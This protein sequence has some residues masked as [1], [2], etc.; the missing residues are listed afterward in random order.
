MIA[1]QFQLFLSYKLVTLI[2]SPLWLLNFIVE[3]NK[4]NSILVKS[5]ANRSFVVILTEI[6]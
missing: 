6:E 2:T 4:D 3:I 1:F 5:Y